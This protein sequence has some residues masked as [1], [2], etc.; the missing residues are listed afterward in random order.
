MNMSLYM[1]VYRYESNKFSHQ[2]IAVVF[3]SL[4]NLLLG[5]DQY[6]AKRPRIPKKYECSPHKARSQGVNHAILS[7]NSIS[8]ASG[9]ILTS[10]L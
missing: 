2:D 6:P 1:S 7:A 9:S 3:A 5:T 8:L 4:F 10:V